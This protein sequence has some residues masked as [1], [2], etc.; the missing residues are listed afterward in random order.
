MTPPNWK[1]WRHTWF[2]PIQAP[3]LNRFLLAVA[4]D[5]SISYDLSFSPMAGQRMTTRYINRSRRLQDQ[6]VRR[7]SQGQL[8]QRVLLVSVVPRGFKAARGLLVPR[9]SKGQ[10]VR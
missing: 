8:G 5:R 1:Q 3:R 2:M 6:Q 7:A 4:K 10:L 9:A